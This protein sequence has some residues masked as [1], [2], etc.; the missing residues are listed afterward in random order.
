MAYTKYNFTNSVDAM[1]IS[2]SNNITSDCYKT[3]FKDN[4]LAFEHWPYWITNTNPKLQSQIN[5]IYPTLNKVIVLTEHEKKV[6][7][8]IGCKNVRVIPNAYSIFPDKQAE[9]N[10]KIVLS[11]GHFNQ[12]KRRDLLIETWKY[13][14]EKHTDWKLRII[15]EGHLKNDVVNR[16]NELNL[17]QSIEILA[18]TK[19]IYKHYYESSI[20][21]MT[22]EFEALPMV[23]IEAKTCGLPCVS[24]DVV[25]GPNEIIRGNE[26]GFLVDYS[27]LKEIANKVCV[28][29]EDEE[30][31]KKFGINARKDALERFSQSKIYKEWDKLLNKI[32][33]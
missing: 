30:L 6:Y 8:N 32:D 1:I 14:A 4:L 22:S 10:S 11:I 9:L 28:L 27:N 19:D 18:P 7:Q 12:Q 13:V 3:T 24:F 15:G 26:D 20:Y 21:L 2:F 33:E 17:N 25:S 16:I 5:K 31:R 29:I 23:L